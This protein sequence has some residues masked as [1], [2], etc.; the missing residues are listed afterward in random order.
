MLSIG[1]A[2]PGYYGAAEE[3]GNIV[4]LKKDFGVRALIAVMIISGVFGLAFYLATKDKLPNEIL[5]GLA[6]VISTLAGFYFG[7]SAK[8]SE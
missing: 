1:R 5:A 6:G 4:K 3:G 8:K 7:T 2:G